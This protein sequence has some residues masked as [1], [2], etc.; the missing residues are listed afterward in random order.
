M[1]IWRSGNMLVMHKQS[2]LP[3]RCVK[4]NEPASDYLRRRLS[5][6]HPLLYLVILANLLI[7]V[8]V[9][10]VV[11]KKADI[12]IGLSEAWF[13]RRRQAMIVGWSCFLAGCGMFF[14]SFLLDISDDV[15]GAALITSIV[16]AM[17]GIF[18]GLLKSRMIVAKKID[19]HFVWLK[20]IHPD[21]LATLP[22]WPYGQR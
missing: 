22:E 17:F 1:G 5:W 10:L 11:S 19:D 21:F 12:K 4:S 8:I 9:A 7:F 18:W 14:A 3:F 15:R 16:L 13:A 2:P 20:G 6:H